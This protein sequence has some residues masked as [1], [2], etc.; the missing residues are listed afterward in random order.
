MKAHA[1]PSSAVFTLATASLLIVLAAGLFPGSTFV[2]QAAAQTPGPVD[3]PNAP[4]N[5]PPELEEDWW[6]TVQEDIRRSD[7]QV[8][9]Q[10]QTTPPGLPLAYHASNRAHD[11][12]TAITSAGL[13]PAA[14]EGLGTTPAWTAESDM[15]FASFGYSV[16]PA[17]DVNGDG[18]ADIIV[19]APYYGNGQ[20]YEGRAYVYYGSAAGV[21]TTAGWIDES[22]QAG[23][24]FGWSVGTAGDVN[25]DGYADVIVGAHYYDNG[26]NDEGR[27]SVYYGSASGLSAT[28]N[29]TA[30]SDQ[31]SAWFGVSVGTAGDVNGDGYAD[32]IVGARNYDH[33]ETDEGAAFVYLGSGSGLSQTAIWTAES[34]QSGGLFGEAVGTAGDVNGDGYADVIVGAILYDN[35]QTNEGRAFAFYGSPTG[36]S[37]TANWTAE[38]DQTFAQFGN[39]AGTAGDVNGD[40]YADIIVG[41]PYFSNG[42]TNEGRAYVY[43]GSAAGLSTTATW[44]TESDQASA[45]LGWKLGTAEDVNGDGYADVIVGAYRYDN[46]QVDEG[47]ATVYH[48]S[49]S[50]LSSTANWTAESNLVGALFGMG[51]GATGDVNGDGYADVVVGAYGYSNGQFMEGRAYVYHGSASSLAAT[52]G[53]TDQRGGMFGQSVASAGDVNGDGYDDVIV[54][55][56]YYGNYFGKAWLYQGGPTGLSSIPNWSKDGATANDRFG[57]S[58]AAAG[59]V[60]GDGYGDVIV[61]AYGGAGPAPYSGMTYVFYGSSSGLGATAGWSAAGEAANQYFGWS[62]SSAGDVNGDGYA[63]VAVGSFNAIGGSGKAWAFYG[64][65]DG[66]SASPNWTAMGGND[67]FGYQ[68]AS[69]GDVNADGYDDVVIGAPWYNAQ[70]GRARVYFGSATGLGATAGWTQNGEAAPGRF[71]HSVASAGDVNGDGFDD[72]LIGANGDAGKAYL[73]PGGNSGPATTASWTATGESAG[74]QFGSSVASAGD[75]NG[76]GRA[77]V[78]VGASTRA[79]STGKTYVYHGS[80]SGLDAL[81]AWTATG[82][83]TNSDFGSSVDSAG[84]VNGDGYT[85]VTVGARQMNSYSGKAYLYYGNGGA[86]MAV[87]PQQR[88]VDDSAPVAPGGQPI[89]PNQM[90]LAALAR[91][92]SGRS[93]VRLQWEVKE[94]GVAFNGSGLGQS[95]WVEGGTAGLAFSQQVSGLSFEKRFH[96]RV[97]IVGRPARAATNSAV[98]FRSRWLYGPTFFTALSGA[99]SIAGAGQTNLLAQS[100]Y[101]DVTNLGS[102]ALT[103]LT[104]RSYPNTAHAR[105]SA[106][107]GFSGGSQVLDRYFSVSP[108]DNAAGYR[109]NLCLNYDDAE[110]TA[111]GATETQLILCRWTGS[112]WSC[113]ARGM[114][115]D[116]GANLVCADDVTAFSDWIIAQG[117]PLAVT[118]AEF[119]AAQVNNA[120]LATWE[121]VSELNNRGFNLWRGA[122]PTGPDTQLNNTLIPSQSQGNPSGFV[123]TWIDQ[124]NLVPGTT[125]YYWLEN[126]STTGAV[127]RHGPVSVFFQAPTAVRLRELSAGSM[128][129]EI[130]AWPVALAVLASLTAGLMRQ[131]RQSARQ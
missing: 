121:T 84:D 68:V 43:H 46:G 19:G 108:N 67:N 42:Q 11:M 112:A 51:V 56:C 124:D 131:Q 119:S 75:V 21:S 40:G 82:E 44:S 106:Y 93:Q 24:N 31:V 120:I 26:Q 76:D 39:A 92:P 72:L 54:G 63:D 41:A 17:G 130:A 96:W 111:A 69:A 13:A 45:F 47:R 34:N 129:D 90:R 126:V 80:A 114:G 113:V 70:M 117:S 4:P 71:G 60:N 94:E 36:P 91:T 35:G 89:G 62:V 81:P 3:K 88:R 115:T 10:E 87:K 23:A 2:L 59:D 105:K 32:V 58:V 118:L 22:N 85:D 16:G 110:V 15:E 101:I 14:P 83:A 18:Y 20:T 86:G 6:A 100:A 97:R 128:G 104:L 33:G 116:I 127:T 103:S 77:D 123:Y 25:G 57:C 49:A 55:S 53:W 65:K 64:S 66:L 29:W 74:D 37:T 78:V 79:S 50:G 109:T 99:Q 122:S 27:A 98:T 61:G 30:E 52:A 102:P 107:S 5:L 9:W 125:Y 28:A 38:S 73:Y 1:R 7:Y 8:T 95:A 12:H 48:G